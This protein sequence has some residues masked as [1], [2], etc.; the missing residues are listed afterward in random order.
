[1]TLLL[2]G[3]A[4]A[5]AG[6]LGPFEDEVVDRTQLRLEAVDAPLCEAPLEQPVQLPPVDGHLHI[7]DP[8]RAWG[9]PY[10]IDLLHAVTRQVSY[11]LPD[12]DPVFIGD[13]SRRAGGPL[14]GHR[15]HRTGRDADIGLF[16]DEGFQP[17]FGFEAIASSEL[18]LQ[19]NWV[20]IRELLASDRVEVILLD[21]RH[22]DALTSWLRAHALLTEAE[23]AE[24]FPPF[25]APGL[26]QRTGIVRAARNHHDHMHVRVRC[27]R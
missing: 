12:A 7:F 20:L 17:L 4:L 18:D 11:H 19:A 23:I 26:S 27:R 3:V 24:T 25:N 5:Q 1:V 16:F 15:D 14:Y 13:I 9:T 6:M 2:L 21:L 8:D 10:L 22:I